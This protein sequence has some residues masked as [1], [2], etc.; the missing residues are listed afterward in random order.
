MVNVSSNPCPVFLG[1]RDS[2]EEQTQIDLEKVH[3]WYENRT[4]FTRHIFY[5]QI[6]NSKPP[7]LIKKLPIS[8]VIK[9][10]NRAD[11]QLHES[12]CN[13]LDDEDDEI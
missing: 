8:E 12:L 7:R 2:S 13:G 11:R 6:V 5:F 1:F 10:V 4:L 9:L 3:L